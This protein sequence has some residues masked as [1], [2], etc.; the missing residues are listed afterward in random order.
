MPDGM[1]LDINGNGDRTGI[2][3]LYL[4]QETSGDVLDVSG[5]NPALHLYIDNNSAVQRDPGVLTI[6]SP[7]LIR[8]YNPADKIIN[9]CRSSEAFTMEAWIQNTDQQPA[10]ATSEDSSEIPKQPVRIVTLSTTTQIHNFLF[11]QF[12]LDTDRYKGAVRTTLSESSDS[13]SA[14]NSPITTPSGVLEIQQLQHVYFTRD[15]SGLGRIYV[16]DR[17]GRSLKRSTESE[18]FGG[19]LTN[20]R[21][22]MYLG[23]GNEIDYQISLTN[24]VSNPG[25]NRAW[26]GQF[27]LLAI[28]CRA[29]SEQEILGAAASDN[30][31][32]PVYTPDLY[33]PITMARMRA[34]QIHARLTGL[35]TPLSHPMLKQMETLIAQGNL[36]DAAG[37]AVGASGLGTGDPNFFNITVRDFAARMSTREESINS[38]LSDFI[39]TVVGSI[40]DDLDARQLLIGDFYYRG[41]PSKAAV[42][43]DLVADLL[44]SNRHYK[45]L[46]DNRFNLAKVLEKVN[47]Q[48]L[49]NG[50]AAVTNPDPAGL[51]TT[52]GFMEAH[53]TAGTNRR[54]IEYSFREFL[55]IPIEKWADSLG[56]D[57]YVGQDVDRFPGGDH[58][59]FRSTCRACHSVM[60]SLRGA[61]ARFTFANNFTKN[62]LVMPMGSSQ[63]D[64]DPQSMSQN[65]AYV[66][67]K[68]NQNSDVFALGYRT[69]DD[70]FFNNA[71]QGL[72]AQYFGWP[73]KTSGNG[74]RQLGEMI[75][76]STAFPKCMATRVFRSV[77]KREPTEIE[78]SIITA[79]AEDF[80]TKNY[81]FKCL[82]QK[83]IT[84]PN[85]LGAL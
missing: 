43:V 76:N 77:C 21:N 30:G 55:C 6:V 27:H 85:C 38:P 74:V 33:E 40:R 59:K 29:L 35:N 42:S 56:P 58:N 67:A 34:Q 28:Y 81:N 32:Q 3:A 64:D 11:G 24:P 26:R 66:A 1:T 39:A 60:D 19:S 70:R 46:E 15:S 57:N 53:A 5:V 84:E 50:Q 31:Q 61:F 73:D 75:A 82:F 47:G 18:G 10:R 16:S 36:M 7:T 52:R 25:E 12:Y 14:L 23:L 69:L 49:F 41:D 83:I 65:P 54:L 2:V 63:N 68:M 45:E 20:W 48:M 37:V 8:S 80:K 22:G 4:F 9:A 72:N 51:L 17:F 44:T 78:N 62:T 79:A 71:T 13:Q